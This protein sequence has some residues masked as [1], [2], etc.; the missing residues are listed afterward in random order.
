MKLSLLF[1]FALLLCSN[2]IA[3]AKINK[4]DTIYSDENDQ[5]IDKRVFNFKYKSNL[6]YGIRFENDTIVLNR[7][8]FTFLFGE[9]EDSKKNQIFKLIAKRNK[10]DT[11]Q[12]IVIH[13]T[14][15]LKSMDEFP[16]NNSIVY[17][18]DS[19]THKHVYSHKNFI[20]SHKKCIK[21]FKKNK[22]ANVYH[23]YNINNGHPE[24]FKEY[25]W[26]K[27]HYRLITNMFSD[28][29]KRFNTIIINPDG[30]FFCFNFREDNNISIYNDIVKNKKWE[31]H[32]ASFKK[33]LKSLNSL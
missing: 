7:L 5:I 12:L 16:K 27:D 25:T 14:D 1:F 6:F 4:K 21:N 30:D 8:R 22:K 2:S 17:N 33:R 9:I 20:L 23:F 26:Q 18:K 10:V 31:K 15:T 3:Q 32:K 28:S 19:T 13:Y 11:T 29:Y 24:K